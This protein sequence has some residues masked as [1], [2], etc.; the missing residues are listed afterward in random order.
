MKGRASRSFL[1]AFWEHGQR[2]LSVSHAELAAE[3]RRAQEL[4]AEVAAWK[5]RKGDSEVKEKRWKK[6]D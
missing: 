6:I 2:Q 4:S 5:A 3:R 1:E